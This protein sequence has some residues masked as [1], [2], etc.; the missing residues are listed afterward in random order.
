[1]SET[2]GVYN[3]VVD[4]PLPASSETL[5][6]LLPEDEQWPTQ[7]AWSE[8]DYLR[9][10]S[11]TNWLIEYSDG[12][13]EVLPMPTDPH[14]AIV[15]YLFGELRDVL[16]TRRG[17][18][19]S[20]PLSLRLPSGKFREP[21]VLALFVHGDP[22]RSKAHWTGADLVMEVVSPDDPARDTKQKRQEYADAGIPEY[23]IV[24]PRDESISVLVLEDTS[25][26]DEARYV[27]GDTAQSVRLPEFAVSVAEVFDAD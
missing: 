21:D 11:L 23:W 12:F 26:R 6:A 1:M 10:A 3:V 25:Y 18:I 9:L 7:G 2:K 15:G 20:A 27:R 8:A 17:H 14:Q 22:R 24:D 19:R 16:R 4:P 13:I 5:A